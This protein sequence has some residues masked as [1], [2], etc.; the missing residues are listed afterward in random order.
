MIQCRL[1]SDIIILANAH[2]FIPHLAPLKLCEGEEGMPPRAHGFP[3]HRLRKACASAK[4]MAT[5]RQR[6]EVGG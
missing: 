2:P 5:R 3:P 1:I 4:A 6:S